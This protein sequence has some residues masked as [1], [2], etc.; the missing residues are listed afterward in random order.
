LVV[1]LDDRTD[2]IWVADGLDEITNDELDDII[3][4]TLEPRL[5]DGDFGGA[6]IA[7]AEALGLASTEAPEP[8]TGPTP[9]DRPDGGGGG[10][11]DAGG[12]IGI[13]LLGLG[14]VL[15]GVWLA[16][17]VSRGLASRREAEERDRRTG[18]LAREANAQLIA[19]DER[20]RTAD[21]EA[22]FVEAEFG[23]AAAAP[24][25]AAITQAREELRAA[26][27]VRQRLDDAEPEDPPTRERMLTEIVER[28]GR[29]AAALDAQ[30]ERI[31]E[32]RSLERNAPAVLARL[33]EQLAAQ[34]ARL[35][36]AEAAI[37]GLRRFA[38]ETW[39]SV[40]GNVVEARK[41]LAGARA[42]IERARTEAGGDA[43]AG[44]T[45]PGAGPSRGLV[46]E[47]I[48]AQEGVAGA[49]TLLDALD[50]QVVRV[51]EAEA[52]L[53][54]ELR[55]AEADLA[56]ARSA[57]GGGGP[58]RPEVPK[59]ADAETALRSAR[60]AASATPR[61][62]VAGHR[63]AVAARGAAA[64]ALA[65]ARGVAAERARVVAAVDAAIGSA[66]AD[67][68]RAS[69]FIATR[70]NGVGRQARTRLAEAERTLEGA[71]AVRDT[72]PK[73][74]LDQ[75]RRAERLAE[76]AYSLAAGDFGRWDAG[77]PSPAGGGVD[78]GGVILGTILG[79]ILSGGG[80][81]GGW[82]GSSWGTPGSGGRQGGLRLPR[83]GGGGGWGGGR[84]RGGS[85]G[86]FGGS[87]GGF[88]GF[89]GGGGGGRSRGGRW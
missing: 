70:R 84:S 72:D 25:R 28:C 33:P 80:R 83:G 20:I 59:L 4:G 45:S 39:K 79:N 14:L 22:G 9:T 68:N 86:G 47:L 50:A 89:G 1:A 60:E 19:I 63:H 75:A 77:G 57:V 21:Q 43:G 11:T 15:V 61:D 12:F 3:A 5:A 13:V 54:D 27:A 67:V 17:R 2:S 66:S 38:P 74:A 32:L 6:V 48:V 46:R 87:R 71:R 82:G 81:G 78:L 62:P 31:N 36:G 49:R 35:G 44:D 41:G 85:F 34:E 23:D 69:D 65:A 29:A 52:A 40:D 73:A 53:A 55:A 16:S 26:F 76:E 24:F 30:A 51:R 37:A 58:G 10:G 18:K 42:A 64:E 8:T 7:T 88:G 56:T